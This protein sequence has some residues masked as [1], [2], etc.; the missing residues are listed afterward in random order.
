MSFPYPVYPSLNHTNKMRFI[1]EESVNVFLEKFDEDERPQC[2]GAYLY[3]H[4]ETGFDF[5]PGMY[6]EFR[7]F[8]SYLKEFLQ[9]NSMLNGLS[10]FEHQMCVL[11]LMRYYR[12]LDCTE[13]D[14][15]YIGF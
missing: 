10:W 1:F 5:P 4:N 8:V 9:H 11:E 13:F 6:K 15:L 7:G 2:Y 3:N 12:S 14:E